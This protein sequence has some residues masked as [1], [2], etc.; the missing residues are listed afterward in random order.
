MVEHK[1]RFIDKKQIEGEFEF[2]SYVL[3]YYRNKD[4]DE[5][6]NNSPIL[7]ARFEQGLSN[8]EIQCKFTISEEVLRRLLVKVDAFA[9]DKW[10]QIKNE[11]IKTG[12]PH[13][14]KWGSLCQKCR[15]LIS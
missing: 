12:Q 2:V 14:K 10:E 11:E 9:K 1:K 15:T 13:S 6:T 7:F 3:N 4:I 5:K 8:K